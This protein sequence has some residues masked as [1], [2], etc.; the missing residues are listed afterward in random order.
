VP[1]RRHRQNLAHQLS[2]F[3][4]RQPALSCQ[5]QPPSILLSSQTHDRQA[6]AL[7]RADSRRITLGQTANGGCRTRKFLDRT[8]DGP[9]PAGSCE[10]GL[11]TIRECYNGRDQSVAAV[12]AMPSNESDSR[13]PIAVI[14]R[15][16]GEPSHFAGLTSNRVSC[17][18]DKDALRYCIVRFAEAPFLLCSKFCRITP[19]IRRF[20]LRLVT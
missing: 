19:R 6:A 16:W 12:A 3:P 18:S 8:A 20:V 15:A 14:G 5:Q 7:M 9:S 10:H 13:N 11:L 2:P 17:S 4:D 1:R